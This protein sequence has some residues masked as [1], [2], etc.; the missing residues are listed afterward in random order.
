MYRM[1]DNKLIKPETRQ[2]I[3]MTEDISN[4]ETQLLL[5]IDDLV[6]SYDRKHQVDVGILDFSRVFDTVPHERLL[7]KL[8]QSGVRGP[9]LDWV[10]SFLSDWKM[11][12]AVDGVYSPWAGVTSCVPWG[13]VLGPFLFLIYI[14]D[15]P[16]CGHH[17]GHRCAYL[18]RQLSGIPGNTL[19]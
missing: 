17:G 9:I 13:T 2:C 3:L 4:C 12:V 18:C 7:G 8:A 19:P 16:D 10:H 6:R 14:N 15:L 11:R 1:R 5:T